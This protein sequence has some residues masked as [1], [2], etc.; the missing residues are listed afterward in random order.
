MGARRAA[1]AQLPQQP[2]RRG[3]AAVASSRGG[4]TLPRRTT[5]CS[6]PTRPTA[7]SGS[8]TARP[9]S[10]LAT[11]DLTQRRGPADAEQALVDDRVSQRVRGRRPRSDRRRSTAAPGRRGHAAG[12]RPAREHRGVG[13]RAPRRGQP[14]RGTRP[15]ARSSSTCSRGTACAW[16][17][18]RRPSTCGSRCPATGRRSSGRSSCSTADVVVAPGSFFGP[19]GEGFVR[20]AMVPTLEEC[21]R[22]A[23]ALERI[24][25]GVSA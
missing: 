13:R 22:A 8:A 17:A 16:R 3:R 10:V 9:P 1:V 24:F 20:M 4:R 21:E 15:N 25:A 12:V 6:P 2:D 18:A 19:E 23:A 5:C 14:R 7:S 11:G